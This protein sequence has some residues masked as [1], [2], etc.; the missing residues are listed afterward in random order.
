VYSSSLSKTFHDGGRPYPLPPPS[1]IITINC[2]HQNS[3]M[4]EVLPNF[5][6]DWK[7]GG[8]TKQ[9]AVGESH[10]C[11]LNNNQPMAGITGNHLPI[12][13]HSHDLYV[14]IHFPSKTYSSTSNIGLFERGNCTMANNNTQF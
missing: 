7:L 4:A 2:K 5:P 3:N 13:M 6:A 1:S 11:K 12:V 14:L 9:L 10:H 8:G